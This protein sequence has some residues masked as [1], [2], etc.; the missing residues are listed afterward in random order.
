MAAQNGH[1]KC[2]TLLLEKGG[3][4][5]QRDSEDRNYLTVAI[6]NHHKYGLYTCTIVAIGYDIIII[7][8]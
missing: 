1:T 5:L 7:F 4:V 8:S 3:N 6:Q 2:V